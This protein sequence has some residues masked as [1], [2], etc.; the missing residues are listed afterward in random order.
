MGISLVAISLVT[1]SVAGG[2]DMTGKEGPVVIGEALGDEH[3]R[4]CRR[5]FH[6]RN[7]R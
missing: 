5:E 6:A 4:P 7:C 2:V 3:Q 1:I